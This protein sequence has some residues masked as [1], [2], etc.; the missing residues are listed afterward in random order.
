MAPDR[1][2]PAKD[3]YFIFHQNP[4]WL[5]L[6]KWNSWWQTFQSSHHF[7]IPKQTT[8]SFFKPAVAIA[9]AESALLKNK[10]TWSRHFGN[11]RVVLGGEIY[12]HRPALGAGGSHGSLR[13]QVRVR[14]AESTNVT[15][16]HHP[17]LR[18]AH[19]SRLSVRPG[20]PISK[21]GSAYICRIC[22][23]W[24]V[25]YSAYWFKRLHIILHITT[26]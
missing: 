19:P 13:I 12:N 7:H 21:V 14:P 22:R 23:I 10:L 16:V 15:S 17:I 3:M 20:L 18:A 9:R 2:P 11:C 6:L 24:T 25:H 1:H 26:Y 4:T 8:F 5:R